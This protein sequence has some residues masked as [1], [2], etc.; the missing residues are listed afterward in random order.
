[1]QQLLWIALGGSIGAVFRYLLSSAIYQFTGR[2]FPYGTL[3][4]NVLGSF[5]IGVLSI[6]LVEKYQLSSELRLAIIVGGLGAFTTF[7]TFS[8]ETIQLIEQGALMR[9]GLNI[10]LSV[11]LCLLGTWLGM[12]WARQSV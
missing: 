12:M 2:D 1:M 7:S 11:V 4:V 10:V 5:I 6:W 9:A 8:W 3:M